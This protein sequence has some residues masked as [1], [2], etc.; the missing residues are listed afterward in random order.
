VLR[1]RVEVVLE[2]DLSPDHAR[3]EYQRARVR[4]EAG[5]LVASSTGLQGSS[6]L[7]SML[8]ANALLEIQPGGDL[9][10]AGTS[11]PALLTGPLAG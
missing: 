11:V 5:R 8:G 2:H 9:L 6:R 7:A 10:S 1:P 3:L 4:W